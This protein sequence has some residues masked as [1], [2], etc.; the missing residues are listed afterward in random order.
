MPTMTSW[1]I[2]IS[3]MTHYDFIVF[4]NWH[5]A[6]THKYDVSLIARLLQHAGVKV[7]ILDIY[8]DDHTDEID[9]VPV[10]HLMHNHTVPNDYWQKHPKNK[11]HSMLCTFRFLWQQYSY[12]RHV[13]KE[14][15]PMTDR[16]YCGSY[17]GMMPINFFY[18]KK[19]CYYWGLRSSHMTNF[20]MHFRKNPVIGIRLLFLRHA[21]KKNKSQNL[22]V[23]NQIIKQEFEALGISD[24][25]LVIREERC[26]NGIE[27]S[28][29]EKLSS[30]FSLLTIGILRSDKRIEYTVKEFLDN[31][32]SIKW[33]YVLAGRPID[34][35]Y[36]R[37][38]ED[39]IKG[40]DN[41]CRINEFMDYDRFY[42]LIRES[43]F[44]I[45]ADKKKPS[46]ITNGTMM[47][48]ILNYRPII[49]P[50]YNPY[51]YYIEKYGIG[52]MFDPDKP[53]DL[54]RAMTDA[55]NLG[56]ESFQ[57]NIKTFLKTIEFDN[58]SKELY[59]EIYNETRM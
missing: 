47:E 20:W 4:E 23:S 46:S 5:S 17:Y 51:K 54:S 55:E 10:V 24:K 3:R 27:Q 34:K 41:I 58:V 38:V 28:Q 25:R 12:M 7:A 37:K 14:I 44:V 53:G 50:N 29:Y 33:N 52:I 6:V 1:R 43:H 40:H 16:F 31:P 30:C 15:E 56:T 35:K 45:L 19:N 39:A 13:R 59:N 11:F 21:F 48:A 32:N 49:A 8:H 26:S 9:G 36:E 22:F 18:S 57:E 42:N 2:F